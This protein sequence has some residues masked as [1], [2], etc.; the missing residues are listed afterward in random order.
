MKNLLFLITFLV[1]VFSYQFSSAQ[2]QQ[3]NSGTYA[4]LYSLYF[5]SSDTGYA[6][7]SGVIIIKTTDGG[8]HWKNQNSGITNRNLLSVFFINSKIGYIVG[9][10]GSIGF[11]LNTTDGGQTWIKHDSIVTS[12]LSSIYFPSANIGYAVGG[13]GFIVKTNDA[14]KNWKNLDYDINKVNSLYSVYFTDTLTGF[15]VGDAFTEDIYGVIVST[16]D[17]GK[18]WIVHDSVCNNGFFM[19]IF[20]PDSNNGY[21]AGNSAV[22]KTNDKGKNWFPVSSIMWGT[23]CFFSSKDTGYVVSGYGEIHK[24]I[25]GGTSWINESIGLNINLYS[26]FFP[27]NYTGF[28]SGDYGTIL[29]YTNPNVGIKERTTNNEQLTMKIS[30][31]P[32]TDQTTITYNLPEPAQVILSI[33]DLTGRTIITQNPEPKAQNGLNKITINTADLNAGI[34]FLKLQTNNASSVAKFV[35]Q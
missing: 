8:N 1:S 19:S 16:V 31:N 15:A 11:V 3:L 14:G 23:A 13:N 27:D 17:G 18:N 30:P 34:Y 2:W 4:S 6:V 10:D 7:G 20:L 33:Y 29:K 5:T 32:A 24:T 9:G 25:N 12:T 26:V 22:F 35:K 21:I 28:I